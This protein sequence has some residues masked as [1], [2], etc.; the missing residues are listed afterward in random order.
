MQSARAGTSLLRGEWSLTRSIF[1]SHSRCYTAANAQPRNAARSD[2]RAVLAHRGRRCAGPRTVRARRLASRRRQSPL[3]VRR[4]CG[5]ARRCCRRR[6]RVPGPSIVTRVLA[7]WTGPL[8]MAVVAAAV[9]HADADAPVLALVVLLAPLA[10]LL[11]PLAP[12]DITP[13]SPRT[14]ITLTVIVLV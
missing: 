5:A 13:R 12:A 1:S 3:V 6:G 10:G 2:A 7:A 14:V 9:L 8:A 11:R 4:G